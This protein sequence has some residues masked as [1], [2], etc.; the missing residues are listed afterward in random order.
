[1]K[2][3]TIRLLSVTFNFQLLQRDISQF[4]GAI[5]GATQ[6]KN[7]LFHNHTNN[8][9]IYRYPLIQYK[10]IRKSAAIIC[11][12]QGVDGIQDFFSNT[13]WKLEINRRTADFKVD[14][15]QAWLH[16]VGIWEQTFQ[17]K[18]FGWLPLNQAN[19]KKYQQLNSLAEKILFLEKIL[20]GHILGFLEGIDLKAEDQVKVSITNILSE[21]V[22]Q[23]KN[24][25]MQAFSVTFRTN[26]SL[27]NYIG[28]GK[29]SSVGFGVL[30]E[31]MKEKNQ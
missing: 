21:Q 16:R 19:Y 25:A 8:G 31:I 11:I 30:K 9:T 1:M 3:K 29:G 24:Q 10:N 12:E 17:F 27:P 13:N 23:Y 28:L 5:I 7:D 22:M 26:V 15:L 6:L 4:R 2:N 14:Q 18:I 20:T